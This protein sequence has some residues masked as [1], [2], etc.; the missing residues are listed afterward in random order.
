[1]I[2][3]K[4]YPRL[5]HGATVDFNLTNLDS[6]LIRVQDPLGK[7][8]VPADTVPLPPAGTISFSLKLPPL[9]Y[10]MCGWVMRE[11]DGAMTRY[12]MK[13]RWV[14]LFNGMLV[15]Y[16]DQYTLNDRKGVLFLDEVTSMTPIQH[17]EGPAIVLSSGPTPADKW[18]IMWDPNEPRQINQMWER[19]LKR[20]LPK[21][22][23]EAYEAAVAGATNSKK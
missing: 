16:E 20:C 21:E 1:V 22:V 18:T 14:I 9:P 3:I 10:S 15:Y 17:K 7:D 19:K 4:N 8:L 6:Y 12:Q 23:V 5:Y 13:R 11:S 2:E